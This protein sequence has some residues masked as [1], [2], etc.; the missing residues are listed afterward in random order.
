MARCYPEIGDGSDFRVRY[1]RVA[2]HQLRDL[3]WPAFAAIEKRSAVAVLPLGA[4]EAHGPHLPL[5][6]DIVIAEA[7][8][9][10]GAER[11]SARG[12][13]VV[14]LPAI[15]IAPA[16]FAAAFAGTLDTS[17]DAATAVILGIA[18]SLARAGVHTLAIAN[19]H[20][21]PA[22]VA[23]IRTAV[24]ASGPSETTIVF[25]DL[26]RRRWAERLT[27]EFRSGACHAGRYEGSIVL[28]SA[29]AL[30]D[31]TRRATLPPNP[32]SL[33]D[34]IRRGVHTFAEAGGPHAYFGSP[35]DATAAEGREIIV[36]LGEILVDAVVET[37]AVKNEERTKAE[38]SARRTLNEG[39]TEA[40]LLPINPVALGRPVGF[41]HGMLAPAGVRALYVAGQTA[42]DSTG[43]MVADDFVGQFR[44]AL[45]RV[46][47]VVRASGGAPTDVARM[48]IYVTD[49]QKYRAART[50]LGPEWTAQMGRHYPAMALVEVKGLVDPGALVE[51]QADAILPAAAAADTSRES[52]R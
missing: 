2:V 1:R 11:L 42:T 41:A 27:D 29:P 18:N 24:H 25:P 44:A 12:F 16:P 34:A 20:H 3:T 37:L 49:L 14:V 30:V 4:I 39:R 32:Q 40:T 5:G 9:R 33:V 50:A 23:A 15:P 22:H 35:A 51:I 28:A 31:E 13:E 48:T 38:D 10:A 52:A 6:T 36:R 43:S 7:M 21:D 47:D 26:T 46:L 19:A 17:A 8:A 45:Q